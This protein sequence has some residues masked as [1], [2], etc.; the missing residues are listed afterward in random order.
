MKALSIPKLERKDALLKIATR[1][2]V[3]IVNARTVK[4]KNIFMWT[5]NNAVLQWLSFNFKVNSLRR[6]VHRRNT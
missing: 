2:K 6:K 4:M 1:L 3:E 5:D